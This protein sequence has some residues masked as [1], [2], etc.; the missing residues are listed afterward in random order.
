MLLPVLISISYFD[1]QAINEIAEWNK[2]DL[3]IRKLTSPNIFKSRSLRFVRPLENSVF[4][5]HNAIGIENKNKAWIQS[6]SL[7]QI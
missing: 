7:P 4:T 2:L 3:S 1:W 5:C 6:P